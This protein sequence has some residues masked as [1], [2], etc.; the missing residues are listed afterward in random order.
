MFY[1]TSLS[2]VCGVGCCGGWNVGGT[3]VVAVVAVAVAV[4]GAL[5]QRAKSGWCL[6]C[7]ETWDVA[8]VLGLFCLLRP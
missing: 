6:L 8:S 7:P 1:A 5:E 2:R 4:C 3:W